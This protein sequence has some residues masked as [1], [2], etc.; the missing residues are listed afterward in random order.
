VRVSDFHRK[1]TEFNSQSKLHHRDKNFH[2]KFSRRNI[3][4]YGY[5]SLSWLFQTT[6]KPLHPMLPLLHAYATVLPN[7]HVCLTIE[8]KINFWSPHKAIFWLR[9]RKY[10]RQK[11]Q[12]ALFIP[13][14]IWRQMVTANYVLPRLLR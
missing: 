6:L 2:F 9:R 4:A 1:S 13:M 5:P 3:F 8:L 12:L 10:Y 7:E 14:S 11:D